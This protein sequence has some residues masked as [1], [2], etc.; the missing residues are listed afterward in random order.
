MSNTPNNPIEVFANMF[1]GGQDAYGDAPHADPMAGFVALTRQMTEAQQQFMK[2]MTDYW[3]GKPSAAGDAGKAGTG[4]DKRFSADAWRSDP[5]FDL[6]R[7]TYLA[8][9]DFLKGA[10]ESVPLDEDTKAR[11]RFG[12]RQF[13]DAMSPSNFFATNPEAMQLAAETGG[14][15][16]VQGMNLF[17]EDLGKGRVSSTDEKAYVVGKDLAATKGAVIFQ[18]DMIQLIQ[19]A[20]TT[21][22]VHERPLLM[23]PPCINKFYI[24]DLQ[25]ENSIVR[26]AVSQGHTVFM[27]S[28]RNAGPEQGHWT[29]DDYLKD[30]VMRA[31]DVVLEIT[32]ADKVNALGFCVGGTLLSSTIAVQRAKDQ[33]KVSSMTLLTTMLDFSDTGEI[34]SLITPESVAAREASI[35]S[36]GL[37]M[38]KELAF[39]FSSLR[40]NDLIWQYVVNSYLKGKAPP[41]FDMLYWNADSTN[42]PGPMFCWYVRNTYLENNLR[43]AGKTKQCGV[44]VDLSLIDIPTF[45]YASREDHIVPWRTAYASSE[46]VAG[47]TTFV[48]GA[49]G[50]IAGVINPP[51][52]N[53]RNFWVNSTLDPDPDRWFEG[54]QS[55]PGSWWPTWTDWL[56]R[57]AGPMKQAPKTVGNRKYKRVETAPGRYVKQKAE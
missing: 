28:W 33:D 5:R 11:M 32:R 31:I 46:L 12:M 39:T 48:L 40:S 35:G 17:F 54:A 43:V 51:A 47:E 42:L 19:Y 41:A 37:M 7:R 6:V 29:W 2:Q 4:D 22:E 45:L 9:S 15:S 18:N 36:G 49:S 34:G 24:L 21:E 38:G 30:G 26:H 53:K 23:I 3:S 27:V 44:P 13:V 55:V 10:V 50:H 25:P 8:Y 14:A 52:K 20:P 57:L 16:V 1:K 56:S